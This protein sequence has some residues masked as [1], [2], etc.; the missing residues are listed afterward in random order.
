MEARREACRKINE[1]FDLDISVDYR[2]DFREADD[3]IMFT[4]DSGD[5]SQKTMAIDLRT[6]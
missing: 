5:G 2:E 1:M 4:G 6:K 3:E